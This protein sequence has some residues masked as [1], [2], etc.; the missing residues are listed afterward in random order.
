[1]MMIYFSSLTGEL[2]A[3]VAALVDGVTSSEETSA[4][5]AQLSLHAL[6]G[7]NAAD[8]FRLSGQI[9]SKL[10][11]I[12]MDCQRLHCCCFGTHSGSH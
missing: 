9:L 7:D 5:A 6:S 3:E 12:L 8:T 11:A 4:H 1:M 10:V 2:E